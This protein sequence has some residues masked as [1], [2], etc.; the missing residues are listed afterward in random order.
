MK[1]SESGISE[2]DFWMLF[3]AAAELVPGDGY[4][5]YPFGFNI[6]VANIRML[7]HVHS[8]LMN[9]G[10]R[11][12]F[13]ENN[14]GNPSYDLIGRV[15][16]QVGLPITSRCIIEAARMFPFPEPHLHLFKRWDFQPSDENDETYHPGP[17]DALDHELFKEAHDEKFKSYIEDNIDEIHDQLANYW[18][19]P[20]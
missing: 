13:E 9:G 16:S 20:E 7:H 10:L 19:R 1:K 2:D 15:Y 5:E 4:D 11:Y 18:G 8:R 17:F 3:D 14:P 6:P 12:F